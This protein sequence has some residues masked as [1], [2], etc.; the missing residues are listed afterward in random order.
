VVGVTGTFRSHLSV[1]VFVAMLVVAATSWLAA[2]ARAD[3]I[4]AVGAAGPSGDGLDVALI[5]MATGTHLA[6]PAGINTTS[7]ELD[8]SVTPDGKRLAFERFDPASRTLRIIV[9]DLA[10]GQQAD[11]FTAFEAGQYMPV[12]PT[13]TPDG[14][15]VI[16][17]A[18]SQP[19]GNLFVPTWIETDISGFPTGPFP[20]TVRQQPNLGVSEPGSTSDPSFDPSAG[21]HG[22][23]ALTWHRTHSPPVADAIIVSDSGKDTPVFDNGH[24]IDSP[25][26]SSAAGVLLFVRSGTAPGEFDLAYRTLNTFG[27]P[28]GTTFLL[29][30]VNSSTSSNFSPTFTANGRYIVYAHRPSEGR[31][32]LLV[33]DTATQTLLDP[34]G[35]DPGGDLLGRISVFDKFILKSTQFVTGLNPSVLFTLAAPSAVGILVQRIVGHHRL[36]GRRVPVLRK[37]GRVP[38]GA[39]RRGHH[40]VH[41]DL[42]V[43]GHRLRRGR[44]LISPRALTKKGV[45]RELGKPHVL[46]VR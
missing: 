3:I 14:K 16:T 4:A 13:I 20:H 37:A 31:S 45:V 17:G 42:R 2:A 44:Y 1:K 35:L 9:A 32:H 29:P 10:T 5:D 30:G 27:A 33:Y 8:P 26:Y 25:A 40:R 28:Q 21:V 23:T 38:F 15:T 36:F 34:S 7:E 46:R 22:I 39:F 19:S 24:S 41:W 11:L 43:N 18:A 12:N 6:L